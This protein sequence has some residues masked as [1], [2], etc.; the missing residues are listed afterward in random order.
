[1]VL[2][3]PARFRER[4]P[5]SQPASHAGHPALPHRESRR[6]G[7]LLPKVRRAAIQLLISARTVTSTP[8]GLPARGPRLAQSVRTTRPISGS[9]HT[10]ETTAA[11]P[12]SLPG[13]LHHTRRVASSGA[14]SPEDYLQPSCFG[15]P[16][17]AFRCW[18]WIQSSSA[19][20]SEWLESFTPGRVSFSIIRTYITSLPVEACLKREDGGNRAH[21]F[22]VPVKALSIIFRAKLRDLLKKTQLFAVR[23]IPEYGP[24]HWVVHC[25]PV[26]SGEIAFKYLAPYIFRVAISN[27]RILN[28]EDNGVTF[29]YKD[30][31]TASSP[32]FPPSPPKSSSVVSFSTSCQTDTSRSATMGCSVHAHA[33]CSIK[34]DLFSHLEEQKQQHRLPKNRPQLLVAHTVATNCHCYA[35]SDPVEDSHLE[36]H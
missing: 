20:A 14:L 5:A 1:M 6:P 3:Y 31:A 8:R 36:Q 19:L 10:A 22:L 29:K 4:M 32:D 16:S 30:S 33:T 9:T 21:H 18:L 13:H 35:F 23:R 2:Q 7:L 11:R 12:H 28:V 34:Q 27:N 25:E 24:K 15:H 26:G 17:V